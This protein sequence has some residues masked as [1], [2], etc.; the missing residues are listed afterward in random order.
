MDSAEDPNRD[1]IAHK[2]EHVVA[3]NWQPWLEKA[4]PEYR[5]P[6]SIAILAA[7][8]LQASF[9]EIAS[10][11]FLRFIQWPLVVMELVLLVVLVKLNPRKL[12]NESPWVRRMSWM[13]TGAIVIGNTA[14]AVALDFLIL[15]RDVKDE[16]RVLFGGGAAIFVTNVIAFALLYWELDR[17]GPFAR[18]QTPDKH[19]HPDFLFPQMGQ[20]GRAN[21]TW[22]PNFV[23]YLYVS[24]TNV[25]AFSPTD[26]MPLTRP[27]KAGMAV[28]SLVAVSTIALVIA[29]AVNVLH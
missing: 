4:E 21:R 6:V 5:L 12:E 1:S 2:A 28:Q 8:V 18:R 25:M 23:D 7:M 27:A 22:R 9:A 19:P 16:A 3:V 14:S 29:R 11:R 20:P 17:G 10:T 26:T 24:L 13:L 15:F